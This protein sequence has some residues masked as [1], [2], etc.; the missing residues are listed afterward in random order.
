MTYV[1]TV[2][3]GEVTLHWVLCCSFPR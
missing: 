3:A 1:E 2:T